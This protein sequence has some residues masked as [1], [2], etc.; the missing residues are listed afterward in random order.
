[1]LQFS[2]MKSE[3]NGNSLVLAVYHNPLSQPVWR[4]CH[5]HRIN[6]RLGFVWAAQTPQVV[7]GEQGTFLYKQWSCQERWLRYAKDRQICKQTRVIVIQPS[8][9]QPDIR[10]ISRLP[11]AESDSGSPGWQAAGAQCHKCLQYSCDFYNPQIMIYGRHKLPVGR[12]RDRA[13]AVYCWLQVG[14]NWHLQILES[15]NRNPVVDFSNK[16]GCIYWGTF[17]S[18]LK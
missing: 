14:P 3:I 13:R 16:L 18:L 10:T 6:K 15:S 5:S 9:D 8:Q 11:L 4:S 17:I 1:M 2:I 7:S 12:V